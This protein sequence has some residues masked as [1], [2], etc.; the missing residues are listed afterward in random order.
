MKTL[1][2]NIG[3]QSKKYIIGSVVFLLA[4]LISVQIISYIDETNP[5]T[6]SLIPTFSELKGLFYRDFKK[7][8]LWIDNRK[9]LFEKIDVV[10]SNRL[11]GQQDTE[12]LKQ[13]IICKDCSITLDDTSR[14]VRVEFIQYIDKGSTNNSAP[15]IH[16]PP[17]Y[18][19]YP[20]YSISQNGIN[21]DLSN[22]SY[23]MYGE[24]G[25]SS[26]NNNNTSRERL[27]LYNKDTNMYKMLIIQPNEQI[28]NL[29]FNAVNILVFLLIII[30]FIFIG[31]IIYDISLTLLQKTSQVNEIELFINKNPQKFE[32]EATYR[33]FLE[34]LINQFKISDLEEQHLIMSYDRQ[35]ITT[36]L[37]I[38]KYQNKKINHFIFIDSFKSD[39]NHFKIIHNYFKDNKVSY[40]D[41]SSP[42]ALFFFVSVNLTNNN[43]QLIE[44][45]KLLIEEYNFPLEHGD[46][47]YI[48]EANKE[49]A[50]VF[51]QIFFYTFNSLSIK[52]LEVFSRN[53]PDLAH[54]ADPFLQ[55]KVFDSVVHN[56][57]RHSAVLK[58]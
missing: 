31:F 29:T 40:L 9:E 34:K 1:L 38:F 37:D 57:N 36:V 49:Y 41:I 16:F 10:R 46:L 35:Y 13:K 28:E 3:Y 6:P 15:V 17:G 23:K 39:L 56:N 26:Y 33:N 52:D 45:Y 11:T 2:K 42:S 43:Y 12:V 20:L 47:S 14:P 21:R 19:T 50:S 30:S 48:T 7:N 32:S 25:L 27:I 44:K 54:A 5:K 53:Y 51:S 18:K 8:V 58:L 4:S 55:K 24:E 22:E